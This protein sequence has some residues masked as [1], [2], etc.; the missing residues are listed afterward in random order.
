M[1]DVS[2]MVLGPAWTRGEIEAPAGEKQMGS[3]TAAVY[4]EEQQARFGV[5]EEGYKVEQARA[6]SVGKRACMPDSASQEP[7][8]AEK[9]CR[10]CP[11]ALNTAPPCALPMRWPYRCDVRAAPMQHNKKGCDGQGSHSRGSFWWL[12]HHRRVQR[13][14]MW[15]GAKYRDPL[16]LTDPL[17]LSTPAELPALRR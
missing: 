3:M 13:M 10:D 2:V 16:P 8:V 14:S 15:V 11:E 7:S 17:Q 9:N 5:D 12:T 1:G 6:P 4:T